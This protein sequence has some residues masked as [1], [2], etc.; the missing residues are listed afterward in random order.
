MS[1]HSRL[2]KFRGFTAVLLAGF[3][4]A[5]SGC[6]KLTI[7]YRDP[8]GVA[9]K[10]SAA[11]N[12]YEGSQIES[13]A[14]KKG[15][16]GLFVAAEPERHLAL[17]SDDAIEITNFGD[18]RTSHH[19]NW[20]IFHS[21]V[22]KG[23]SLALKYHYATSG[24]EKNTDKLWATASIA[25][26]VNW[27]KT[28]I[29]QARYLIMW[30]KSS[31]PNAG[32]SPKVAI[33]STTDKKGLK[34]TDYVDASEYAVGKRIGTNWTKV[35][36]PITA[37]PDIQKVD[38]TESQSVVLRLGG[39][40][41]ENKDE[42]LLVDNV[43]FTDDV[44]ITP[45][46]N[47]GYLTRG[48]GVL[49]VWEK[50][51][52]ERPKRFSIKVGDKE[53][54]SVKGSERS[55]IVSKKLLPP[56]KT[57]I[58]SIE[59]VGEDETSNP[60]NLELDLKAP[61]EKAAVV[62]VDA[63]AR[64]QVSP[65]IFGTNWAEPETIK[66]TGVTINRWGGIRT[67][68]YNWEY[69]VDSSGSD[70][71]FMNGYSKPRSTEED[72]KGY[73]GFITKSL[74][75]GA[76]VNYSM[77]IGPYIAKPHMEDGERYCGFPKGKFPKQ[78]SFDP[79]GECGD[80]LEAGGAQGEEK[81]IWTNDP[82]WSNVPN[83][84]DQQRKLLGNLKKLVNERKAQ[85]KK[86]ELLIS[87]DNE[88]GLWFESH[89]DSA[90]KG[91]TADDLV[92]MNTASAALVKEVL[93]DSKVI[94]WSA[95]G[96][97][98]LAGSNMDYTPPGENGYQSYGTFKDPATEQWRDRKQHGYTSQLEYYLKQM[99]AAEK[100]A[101]K[102]LIDIVDVHWYPEAVGVTSDGDTLKLSDNLEPDAALMAQQFDALREWYDPTYTNP[103]WLTQGENKS[104]FWTP[105]HP[106]I[107]AL[108]KLVEQYYPG[109]KL[110][111]NEYDVGSRDYFHG[112]LL[113]VAA[114][115]IFMQEDLYMAQAWYQ[116]ND[117]RSFV[118][119]A[120]QMYGNYDGKG[121]RVGG[122]FYTSKSDNG[123]LLS[124]VTNNGKHWFAVLVNKNPDARLRTTVAFPSNVSK[125]KSYVLSES[126]GQRVLEADSQPAKGDR[127]ALYLPAL[128]ATLVVAE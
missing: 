42:S 6:G 123:D 101:G 58:I 45:V 88:P 32:I 91:L 110:A 29:S 16:P 39:T 13:G 103:T 114:M 66:R 60:V 106:V 97:L 83:T 100:K 28:D 51:P 86:A 2:T 120:Q 125:F 75:A 65:Y 113:R 47:V 77:A 80:G 104:V 12:F 26:G 64:H 25:F 96:A 76:A 44:K 94:G 24:E 108:K 89:R 62:T 49:V 87:M 116:T 35:T 119:L 117:K 7:G 127:I 59:A 37:F 105:F 118:F 55:V 93:P 63:Q 11:K 19:K 17:L 31:D 73:W 10:G 34:T 9:N 85:K 124:Y 61:P 54:V 121:G 40:P 20:M 78:N 36:I 56:G 21:R 98:E 67:T 109:T 99:A 48:D 70:Y 115:G 8:K 72:E 102:R 112:A 22:T 41:P 68:K 95:W 74:D 82:K 15:E 27:P 71:F 33:Q 1:S 14:K 50:A 92:K 111:I 79:S 53:I 52:I 4:L 90:A 128:S 30:L 57:Q 38:I 43:Y 23:K 122:K 5:G 18:R 107:P 69:D 3:T 46:E 84:L 126:L 81:K